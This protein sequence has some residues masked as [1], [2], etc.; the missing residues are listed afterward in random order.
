MS[1]KL[2]GAS[3]GHVILDAKANAGSYTLTLPS[4]GNGELVAADSSGNI[5]ISNAH[6][7]LIFNDTTVYL[8]LCLCPCPRLCRRLFVCYLERHFSV[9]SPTSPTLNIYCP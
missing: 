8:C 4:A 1:L 7:R 9:R 6:P 3:S 5:T 2:N